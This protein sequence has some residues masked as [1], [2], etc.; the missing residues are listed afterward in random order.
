MLTSVLLH[1][2]V[3]VGGWYATRDTRPSM[4]F[5]TY[6]IELVSPPPALQAEDPEVATEE[7][8]VE[9]PEP[10]PAPPAPEEPEE[11]VPIEEPDPEPEPEPPP[12]PEPT[13]EQPPE[14]D[15]E[16][17]P[18]ATPEA[19]PEAEPDV[20]GEDISVRLEGVR[21]DYPQYY[22]NIIRQVQRCFRWRDGGNWETTVFFVI[23]RDGTANDI[24]FVSRS[25]NSAFDFEAMGA[26]DCAGQGRFGPL[27]ED[28]PFETLPVEFSF[29]PTGTDG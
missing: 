29:R 7:L 14:P 1:A 21:R 27:P 5:L 3:L 23:R 13:T 12:E 22:N 18:A 16:A 10:E 28:L 9:R 15:E 19:P 26:V 24:E 8:V 11:V 25:G 6:E 2:A 4:E 17:T 20:S